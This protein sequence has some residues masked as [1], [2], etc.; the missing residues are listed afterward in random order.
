VIGVQAALGEVWRRLDR[1]EKIARQNLTQYQKMGTHPSA[2]YFDGR[3]NT[4][5]QAK[6]TVEQVWDEIVEHN[7]G[8]PEDHP[9]MAVTNHN[10]R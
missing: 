7:G 10:H 4:F 3:V 5:E 6:A 9:L 1:G 2:H 8:K